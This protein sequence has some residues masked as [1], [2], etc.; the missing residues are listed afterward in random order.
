MERPCIQ[1]TS[2]WNISSEWDLN[3]QVSDAVA[4][5]PSE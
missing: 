4:Q 2:E 1:A 5:N 3:M